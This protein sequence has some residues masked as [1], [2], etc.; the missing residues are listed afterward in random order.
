MK[1][2]QGISLPK[3]I[4]IVLA[5][6]VLALWMGTHAASLFGTQNGVIRST[7]S[8][9]FAALILL[10]P[11]Q[12]TETDG[13]TSSLWHIVA[14]LLG[15][16]CIIAGL[17]VPIQHLEWIG[18]L[19][20]LFACLKWS[21][22][23]S[24]GRDTALS[25]LVLYW[26]A[27][28][29]TPWFGRLQIWM[30]I[31]SVEGS[32]WLLHIFNVRAWADGLILHTGIHVFEVPAWCSGMRTATTVFILSL[33][34]GVLRRLKWH[35]TAIFIFWSLFH[36]LL[37]NI[38][39][40]CAMVFFARYTHSELGLEFL[41]DTAGL[42][43]ILG[44]AIVYLEMLYFER[45]KR[46]EQQAREELNVE[47]V[48]ALSEYPP[49]WHSL[50]QNRGTVFLVALMVA[51]IAALAYRSRPYHRAMMLKD[52]AVTLRD[53]G[54]LTNAR[55][56]ANSVSKM[57]PQD[58]EWRF[59]LVRMQLI[60]GEHESVLTELDAM[61]GLAA[62]YLTQKQ[63][64][65]AY[66]LMS[67]GHID[68]AA[69]IVDELP[70]DVRTGDPRV[71]MILAEMALRGGDIGSVAMHVV[72][73]ADWAPNVGRIR[74]LYPYLRIHRQWKAM[75]SADIDIPYTDPVQALSILEA[76]MNLNQVPKVA[77][78]TLQALAR[79]PLDMR[80]LEPLYF[81][82]VKRG[83]G[84]WQERFST[85]LLRAIEA[86][87]N[88]DALYE[89]LHKCFSLSRP[90]LAW[91]IYHRIETID[92]THPT[93]AMSI[94]KYGNK[95]FAFTKRR[96]GIPSAQATEALNLKP[97][98]LL[99][100][101]FPRW[102]R[103]AEYI[104][105]GKL[106]AER[107]TTPARKAAC[108]EAIDHFADHRDEL[109]LDMQYLH[110]F[111]LEM[112]GRIDLAKRELNNIVERYPSE[113]ENAR[114]VLSEVYERKGDWINVYETLRT[115]LEPRDASTEMLSPA[116]IE[117]SW[118][119]DSLAQ[120]TADTI[121]LKPLLRLVR[122]Q[123]ELRLGLA[124]L[125]TART[126]V[127]LYPYST[128]AIE[129]L[130]TAHT[131]L[132]DSE[133]ALNLLSKPRVRDLRQLDL[134]EAKALFETERYNELST[135]SKQVLIPQTRIPESTTQ[136]TSLPPAELAL[137]W[138]RVAIPSEVR[139]VENAE[140]LR[141]N[142][143]T[144]SSGLRKLLELWLEAYE[145]HCE[146]DLANSQRWLNCGR[147]AMERATALNQLAL[148]LC[149]EERYAEAEQAARHAVSVHPELPILWEILVSLSGGDV[150]VIAQA[151]K[152]CPH[153][154]ELWLAELVARTQPGPTG[155][156]D[157]ATQAARCN[158]V[159]STVTEALASEFPPATLTRA[160]EYL[161]RA[162]MRDEA[163]RIAR[164]ITE[165]AR[166]LLPSCIFM[167]RCAL[168]EEDE[169]WALLCTE[170]A[171]AA[172]L[173]PL[174]E[175][176]ENLVTL[177]A[178]DGIID[179]DPD[180]VNALRNLRKSDPTNQI[181][182]QMLGY[183]RFQRGGWEIIDAL[184]EMN[185][186]IAG[187]A[188]NRTPYLIA[189]EVS[190]LL[191]NYDRA[192]DILAQGLEHSPEHPALLNNL[193]YTLSQSNRRLDEAMALVP[194]LLSLADD[195]PQIRDT[196]AAVYIAGGKLD[197]AQ[198]L[199][200]S[201]LRDTEPG[202]P[203]WFRGNLFVAEIA[204]KRGKP[205]EARSLLEGLLKSSRG[206]PDEDILAANTLLA[207]VAGETAEYVNPMRIFVKERLNGKKP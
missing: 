15:V 37:L 192:A 149:R 25:I 71:A 118:P 122:A 110:V 48:E 115:Y 143:G 157:E 36:A 105:H 142:L 203:L 74:N 59:A 58:V 152:A 33:A 193:A 186:A 31:A 200:A 127:E 3:R 160:G 194:D 38:L 144:A 46:R 10:R 140:V 120:R 66:A 167:I 199:A 18:I 75:A 162:N 146:G 197:E 133:E 121:H 153:A 148:L 68:Q 141:R 60:S 150:D 156:V 43:V 4:L 53:R 100:Q 107:D 188:T 108:R 86:C 88:P 164:S 55:R 172:A 63:V 187:G 54:D 174:P 182:P 52:V 83:G 39:R 165:R 184:F 196:L 17:I 185:V 13:D 14:A 70:E 84:E 136:H 42:I 23:R 94:A 119:P 41:H 77:D 90:D 202:S 204:W 29:P 145:Q 97:F 125:H 85:H 158:W 205:R 73:A 129:L 45:R 2:T 21:L 126:T 51:T 175:F 190:R 49:F 80:V 87:D 12:N 50:N 89:T 130:A 176:Y 92:A 206:V 178:A 134:L 173:R 1:Q 112:I 183:I 116:D 180:M 170:K 28:L 16:G 72:T 32:E 99:A 62:V 64:L 26:V 163:T 9:L 128:K 40:I 56:L 201:I 78:I 57:I 159:S 111:A 191:Q 34:L 24:F 67:L 161:W 124:A 151:R 198:L 5:G 76:Y 138:H 91:A 179:T 171:I 109:S 189:S 135:F 154:P 96:L 6:A 81:M 35:E 47:E 131:R 137:L 61:T 102:K 132:G 207:K 20:L 7:L 177:K 195:N 104:P 166:G 168:Y 8:V 101:Q 114:V 11:K 169:D 27:P 82:T 155:V 147:D 139:F 22:P 79:W 123:L 69:E 103:I 113:E 19:L 93:L 44:V 65:M 117:L 95:W 98:F 181:W 30:Q 106:L